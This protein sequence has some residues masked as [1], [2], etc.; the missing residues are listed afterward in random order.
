M[1]VFRNTK[2]LFANEL[3]GSRSNWRITRRPTLQ[4]YFEIITGN[5]SSYDTI[6]IAI[7]LKISFT[8]IKK[9]LI[10][11]CLVCPVNLS[12]FFCIPQMLSQQKFCLRVIA[13]HQAVACNHNI[14]KSFVDFGSMLTRDY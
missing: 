11:I 4:F 7:K 8:K 5:S 13:K 9:K 14:T 3:Y 2:T 12:E 1:N 10:Q 6:N